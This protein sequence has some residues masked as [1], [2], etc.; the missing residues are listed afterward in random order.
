[1]RLNSVQKT[2]CD[3]ILGK[4]KARLN[5]RETSKML[6]LHKSILRGADTPVCDSINLY[7]RGAEHAEKKLGQGSRPLFPP[8]AVGEGQGEGDYSTAKL[9]KSAKNSWGAGT[10]AC[11]SELLPKNQLKKEEEK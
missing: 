3:T 11:Y 6:S 8:P 1:M 9:A 5:M 2:G 4:G 10:P 7:R